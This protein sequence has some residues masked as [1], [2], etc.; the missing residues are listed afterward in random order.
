MKVLKVLLMSFLLTQ[1]STL[2]FA[3]EI[4]DYSSTPRSEVPDQF[5]WKLDHIYKSVDEWKADKTEFAKLIA[6]IEKDAPSWTTSPAKMLTM[7]EMVDRLYLKL[8]HIYAYARRQYDMEMSSSQ[9]S[10]MKGEAQSLWVDAGTKL[11]FMNDDILKMDQKTI[12]SYIKQEPK[13]ETYRFSIEQIL[14]T[15]AHIL[16]LEQEKLIALTG[17]FGNNISDAASILNDVDMPSPEI[18]LSDG[19]KIEL[20]YANFYK[21]RAAKNPEDRALAVK[22]FW[23]N[24]KKFENTFTVLFD[25]GMKQHLFNAKARNFGSCLEARLFQDNIDTSVYYQLIKSV[26]ENLNPLHRYIKLKQELLG[27]PVF[28]YEDLYASAVKNVDKLYTYDE[29]KDIVLKSLGILGAEYQEGLNKA[30]NDGW[31]D[32]YPN[33]DKES[34]AYSDGVYDIHPYIKMNYDG[35]FSN[36]S[37]L[38]HELGHALH[39]YLTAKYQPFVN[40]N[41]TTFLAEIASTFNESLLTDYLMKKETDDYL[42]LFLIDNYLERARQT[43]YRQTLFAEFE[44]AMH[45][46]VE[47]GG[48]LSPDF[49]NKLYL[50][51][52]RKYYGHDKGVTQVDDYIEVEWSKIPHFFMNYYVFQYSTGMIASMALVQNALT[53]GQPAVDKYLGML[54]AGNSDYSIKLLQNAGVDMTQPEPYK[55]AFERFDTL[56]TEMEN[57]VKRL[58]K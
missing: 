22:T 14:R 20:N 15:K 36:V 3:Q 58:K 47:E 34:G 32:V 45:Q 44:L 29:A 16:P 21:Y 41:Y 54:K 1:F 11:T 25:G 53:K 12:D 37:T 51:L 31:I 43:I 38:T 39:S 57:I 55:A 46:K 40:S 4:P 7:L 18:T 8:I 23:K 2:S 56:V 42:K 10:V 35:D 30:F 19:K 6:Q 13:L 50:D 5:K 26:K 9:L 24:H 52:T 17:I 48:S 33:K 28:K 27:L 49:L